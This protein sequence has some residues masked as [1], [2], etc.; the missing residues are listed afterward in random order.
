MQQYENQIK[1]IGFPRTVEAF[2][3]Y[4]QHAQPASEIEAGANYHFFK[5]GVKPT[6][7][8]AVNAQGGKWDLTVG[9]QDR[10]Q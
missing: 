2:W 8:D 4:A 3:R 9:M 6:W 1:E 5:E 10:G 7:E